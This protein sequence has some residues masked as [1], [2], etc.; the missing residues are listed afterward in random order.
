[1][2]IL[3]SLQHPII[4]I[5]APN[6]AP[7][8]H[9]LIRDK[10]LHQKFATWKVADAAGY[11]ERSIK[12]IRSNLRYFGNT[13]APPNCGGRRSYITLHMLEVLREHLECIKD[14]ALSL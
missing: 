3:F 1:M 10:I 5:M 13:K 2:L 14:I 11:S 8:Q 12:A 7:S 6:P 9:D 4:Q